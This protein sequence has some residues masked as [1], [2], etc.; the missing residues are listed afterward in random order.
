MPKETDAAGRLI[1]K[2]TDAAGKPFLKMMSMRWKMR[3]SAPASLPCWH[4]LLFR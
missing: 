4:W 3:R 1:P 2:E